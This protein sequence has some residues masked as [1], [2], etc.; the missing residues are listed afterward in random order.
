M[1]S[2]WFNTASILPFPELLIGQIFHITYLNHLASTWTRFS[3]PKDGGSM[4]FWNIKGT[5]TEIQKKTNK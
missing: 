5:S 4:F 1:H 2:H 3:H